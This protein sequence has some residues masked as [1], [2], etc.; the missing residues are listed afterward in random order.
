MFEVLHITDVHLLG[1]PSRRLLNVDTRGSLEMV[2]TDA[3]AGSAPDALIATGDIAQDGEDEAYRDFLKIVRRFYAGP[4]LCTPGNHD[5]LEPMQQAGLPMDSLT[6]GDWQL[7]PL[8]SHADGELAAGVTDASV[9]E[10][11]AQMRAPHVLLCT[12]HPLLPVDCPWLDADRN[13]NPRLHGRLG[14]PSPVRALVFGHLH[15][16]VAM[17]IGEVPLYGTPSTCF[18]F[19]PKSPRFS[20]DTTAPGYRQIHL[21][22]DGTISTV[23]R[24]TAALP[25]PPRIGS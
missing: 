6:L 13:M 8:D 11:F 21:H 14:A 2:L 4:L 20:L 18:Q 12:H 7:Q 15:Q 17:R 22:D 24:R 25:H 1:E 5:L 3:L 9:D 16:D 19:L 23:V 10:C